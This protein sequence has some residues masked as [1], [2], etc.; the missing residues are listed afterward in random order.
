MDKQKENKRAQMES[1]FDV[2]DII[3]IDNGADS[4]KIGISGED[5]PRKIVDIDAMRDM[6]VYVLDQLLQ[7]NEISSCNI[8]IID[9]PLNSKEY[10]KQIA[11]ILFD[12]MKVNSVLFQNSSTL[13]LFS[14]GETT[15][16][17][18]ESGHSQT[19]CIPVFEGFPI[20]HAFQHTNL[21]G[22]KITEIL[23]EVKYIY[24]FFFLIN[25]YIIK[26]LNKA[27]SI[28]VTDAI[29]KSIKETM[30]N[31]ARDYHIDLNN[32]NI[33]LEEKSYELPD[34]NILDI[35]NTMK[36][37]PPEILFN[38]SIIGDNSMSIN[39]MIMDTL[40]RCDNE[41]QEEL[42]RNVVLCGGSSLFKGFLQRIE[43]ELISQVPSHIQRKDINFIQNSHRRYSAWI[44]GSMLG[45]LS[46]F[47]SLA[48]TKNEYEENSEQKLTIINKKVF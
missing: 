1:E 3:V 24:Y 42:L 2:K 5:H 20:L 43:K 45:S 23:K 22:Q 8:L 18:I 46:T 7:V 21:A 12:D 32:D 17:V 9:S 28:T 26:E 31:V 16:L 10:K 25:T 29:Y 4:V 11:D 47:Q 30:C 13:S 34:G 48:I 44:G 6:Y 41:F 39:Q 38:P 36:Y 19:T 40:G 15:G 14:T 37:K 27:S 33:S 35:T